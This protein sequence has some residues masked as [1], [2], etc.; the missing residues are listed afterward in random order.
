MKKILISA[1]NGT[2]M[3]EL[4]KYLKKSF[5]V[6]GIDS[7]EIGV[8]KKYCDEFY[9]SPSGKDVKFINFIK[10]IGIKVDMIFLFV[11]EELVTVSKNIHKLNKIKDKLILSPPR[12]IDICNDKK[13]FEKFFSEFKNINLPKFKMNKKNIIKPKIG[14]GSKNIF[15]TKNYQ[16][17]KKFQKDKN[18]IVQEFID[19]TEYTV[20]CLFDK[21]GKLIFSLPRERLLAQNVSIIGK[22]IKNKKIN[23]FI[24][25]I[26]SKLNFYGPINVQIIIRKNQ[27][28]LIE[29]NPR[30]SGSIIFS[31]KSNFD[32][33][34]ILFII[35]KI[36]KYKINENK[37]NYNKFFYRYLKSVS[38]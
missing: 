8:A 29:I 11:D 1:A 23:N 16:I 9:K 2:I 32:P 13:K 12:T 35:Q 5:Y 20:D 14:R 34:K 4:V 30:L 37:I 19:G 3:P 28:Y 36:K 26:S 10:K 33:I 25:L 31:I 38:I 21:N 27:L 17:I 7:N 15:I 24:E 18:F 22:T 6:I